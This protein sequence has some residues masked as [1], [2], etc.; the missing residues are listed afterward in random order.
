[1]VISKLEELDIQ[2][3]IN[4]I[5]S[6]KYSSTPEF[7][8]LT[9]DWKNLLNPPPCNDSLQTISE[10]NYVTRI[11]SIINDEQK[12]L[13]LQID[14]EPKK[15]F[16]EILKPRNLV[17]PEKEF[18]EFYETVKPV[19]LNIK[20]QFNRPRPYQLAKVYNKKINVIETKTIHTPAYPSG[21]SFYGMLCFL[22]CKEYYPRLSS[23]LS[24]MVDIISD[25]REYQGVHYRSDT[26]AGI[27]L[28]SIL[29]ERFR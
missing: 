28:A 12:K 14:K 9:F 21:H 22:F 8:K 7:T 20:N 26:S 6:I 18:N 4:N 11:T 19:M 29:Y 2:C 16:Y 3:N 13:I 15:L 17:F 1:M 5:N 24:K 23:E 10:L 25:C 27:S